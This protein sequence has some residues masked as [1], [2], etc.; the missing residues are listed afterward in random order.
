MPSKESKIS[1]SAVAFAMYRIGHG[2]FQIEAIQPE[3]VLK[4]LVET[5]VAWVAGDRWNKLLV[6]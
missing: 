6:D 3:L 2:P 1:S 5:R 4:P